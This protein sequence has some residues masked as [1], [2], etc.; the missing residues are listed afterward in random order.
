MELIRDLIIL[1]PAF[2]LTF[3]FKGFFKALSANFMGDDTPKQEGFLSLNPLVH[4][5]FFNLFIMLFAL[6]F[7][8]GLFGETLPRSYLFMFLILVGA[9]WSIPILINENNFKNYKTGVILTSLA[10]SFGS[11]FLALIFLYINKYFPYRLF[12]QNITISLIP[13]FQS[14]IEFS[15]FFGVLDLIPIPPFDAGRLLQFILP[16]NSE[17]IYELLQ[18]YSFIVLFCLFFVPVISNIFFYILSIL[19]LIVETGLAYLVF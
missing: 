18:Q 16:K 9:R 13:I 17:H 14:V 19:S 3:T 4:I 1:F 7:L 12:Q 8:G 11:F 10:A 5:D 2:L 15:I 6:V